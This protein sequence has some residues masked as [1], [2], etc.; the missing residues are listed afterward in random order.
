ME[1]MAE[2]MLR[3]WVNT[4]PQENVRQADGSVFYTVLVGLKLEVLAHLTG[5]PV[6]E[7]ELKRRANLL[8]LQLEIWPEK[9]ELIQDLWAVR[10]ATAVRNSDGDIVRWTEDL[11][12]D[13][14][15]VEVSPLRDKSEFKEGMLQA[16]VLI[17][18]GWNLDVVPKSAGVVVSD[19]LQARLNAMKD[20]K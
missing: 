2:Q 12:I 9:L 14:N 18:G 16:S 17:K 10:E 1:A 5:F 15:N 3:V 6:K 13:S 20:G 11:V 8:T 4:A 7:L 19:R